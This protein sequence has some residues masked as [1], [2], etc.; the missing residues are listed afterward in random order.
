MMSLSAV[1]SDGHFGFSLFSTGSCCLRITTSASKPWAPPGLISLNISQ[2]T[3]KIFVPISIMR[4]A[5]VQTS[6]LYQ[7]EIFPLFAK[8]FGI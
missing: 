1:V 4:V 2:T 8:F 7:I 6:E 3:S 5:L